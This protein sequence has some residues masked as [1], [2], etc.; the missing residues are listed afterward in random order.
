MAH[1]E[2]QE[3]QQD[4]LLYYANFNWYFSFLIHSVNCLFVQ[5]RLS[6]YLC[7]CPLCFCNL[8]LNSHKCHFSVSFSYSLDY[9]FFPQASILGVFVCFLI[10]F[11]PIMGQHTS[12]YHLCAL[13]EKFDIDSDHLDG[14]T[15]S[16]AWSHMI[17]HCLCF[18]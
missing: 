5:L 3:P 13:C 16:W 9:L 11:H 2:L 18:A 17:N 1:L 10:S 4:R 12:V 14:D 6:S 7:F 15:V 8:S